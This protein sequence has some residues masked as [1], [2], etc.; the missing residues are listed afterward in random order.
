[1]KPLMGTILGTLLPEAARRRAGEMILAG[2]VELYAKGIVVNTSHDLAEIAEIK[3]AT[4]QRLFMPLDPLCQPKAA[5]HDTLLTILTEEGEAVACVG[6]RF[7]HLDGSLYEALVTKSLFYAEPE[8]AHPT[9]RC[10]VTADFAH[11]IEDCP[12]VLTGG[13]W[14]APRKGRADLVAAM[15]RLHNTFI[16]SE[17]LFTWMVGFAEQDVAQRHGLSS[18][19][20]DFAQSGVRLEFPARGIVADTFL[21]AAKRRH[22]RR[23]Y[24]PEAQ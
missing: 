9:D 11:Q 23:L 7:L 4:G 21:L 17:Y 8:M 14:V 22:A 19:G 16:V 24:L 10:I 1:M 15:L 6:S 12:Y 5:A 13:I 20:Y 2:C 18:Y 3:R